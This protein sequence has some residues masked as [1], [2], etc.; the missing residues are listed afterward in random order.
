MP[1]H[2]G[3]GTLRMQTRDRSGKWI[4]KDTNWTQLTHSGG[5]KK[6]AIW[7]VMHFEG[8]TPYAAFWWKPVTANRLSRWREAGCLEQRTRSGQKRCRAVGHVQTWHGGCSLVFIRV[9][10]VR[11]NPVLPENET[12]MAGILSIPPNRLGPWIGNKIALSQN[13]HFFP[14]LTSGSWR[15]NL[16]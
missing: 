16:N 1:F 6:S 11:C 5:K 7:E 3:W 15:W 13:S 12:F 10:S 8:N 4:Y 14:L 2:L 9:T